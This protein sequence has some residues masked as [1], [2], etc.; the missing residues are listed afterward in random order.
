[1]LLIL[2]G[3]FLFVSLFV[4]FFTSLPL[5]SLFTYFFLSFFIF[6]LFVLSFFL[7]V[8]LFTLFS[9]F[10]APASK[11]FRVTWVNK[12]HLHFSFYTVKLGVPVF[13]GVPGCSGVMVFRCSG[14]P[15]FLILVHAL[16]DCGLANCL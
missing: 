15:V 4:P 8:F 16:F 6:Y 3:G 13:R 1:M 12:L 10:L 7:S 9:I 5:I 14:V 2:V 11:L